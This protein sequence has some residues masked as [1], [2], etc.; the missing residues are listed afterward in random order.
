MTVLLNQLTDPDPELWRR[1]FYWYSHEDSIRL[2][3]NYLFSHNSIPPGPRFLSTT[4][5]RFALIDSLQKLHGLGSN[6]VLALEASQHLLSGMVDIFV[7]VSSNDGQPQNGEIPPPPTQHASQAACLYRHESLDL[8]VDLGA[9]LKSMVDKLE[10][11]QRERNKQEESKNHQKKRPRPVDDVEN[12]NNCSS[13]SSKKQK[14]TL[15]SSGTCNAA[16][17]H[18]REDIISNIIPDA[19]SAAFDNIVATELAFSGWRR[20]GSTYMPPSPTTH[21]KY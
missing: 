21:F 10:A 20:K 5:D 6:A 14:L 17:P 18:N 9:Q 3:L 4:G 12:R 1:L 16:K 8:D 13:T 19:T 7:E 15:S 11:E 2:V